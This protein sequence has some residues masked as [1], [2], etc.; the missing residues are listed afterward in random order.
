MVDG[1]FW[2]HSCINQNNC[3]VDEF[4]AKHVTTQK[5]VHTNRNGESRM[6]SG[7]GRSKELASETELVSGHRG[8]GME[9]CSDN[10]V[11]QAHRRPANETG[12]CK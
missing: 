12:C 3:L 2:K 5:D 1:V 9:L 8:L 4:T 7:K 10:T 11:L 6:V